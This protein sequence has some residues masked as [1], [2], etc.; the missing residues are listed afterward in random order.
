MGLSF[1]EREELAHRVEGLYEAA[2]RAESAGQYD[3]ADRLD[4]QAY[5][6]DKRIERAG[7]V[8]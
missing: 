5:E 4:A 6:L 3:A 2:A 1:V 7:G 8:E